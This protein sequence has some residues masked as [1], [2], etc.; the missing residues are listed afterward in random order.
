[1]IIIIIV[2]IIIIIIIIRGFTEQIMNVGNEGNEKPGK[3]SQ[4]IK[5][6][7]FF[8]EKHVKLTYLS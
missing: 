7:H 3:Y 4:R 1:M 6:K 8:L 5:N 2:I